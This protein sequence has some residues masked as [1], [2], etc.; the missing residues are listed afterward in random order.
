MIL[1]VADKLPTDMTSRSQHIP[2][3]YKSFWHLQQRLHFNITPWA[4]L[5][6]SEGSCTTRCNGFEGTC[7]PAMGFFLWCVKGATPDEA[8]T[9]FP[10]LPHRHFPSPQEMASTPGFKPSASNCITGGD[11]FD[12]KKYRGWATACISWQ[13]VNPEQVECN[14]NLVVFLYNCRWVGP[15]LWKLN[16]T[17]VCMS[18]MFC[19]SHLCQICLLLEGIVT[20][21]LTV[22]CWCISRKA[23]QRCRE[24]DSN[25]YK[26]LSTCTFCHVVL[27]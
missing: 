15:L 10:A 17:H 11:F 20:A 22:R 27:Q 2:V 3:G 14:L 6:D 9:A 16:F 25:C 12:D 26:Y 13:L 5:L 23:W 21:W 4:A 1:D 18:V 7:A 24:E 19:F 8:S